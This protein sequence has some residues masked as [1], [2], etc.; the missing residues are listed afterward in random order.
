MVC[1]STNSRPW[2]YRWSIT[3]DVIYA[4][5]IVYRD[6]TIK[7]KKAIPN[8]KTSPVN[9]LCWSD[10]RQL[11]I[12]HMRNVTDGF[13]NNCYWFRNSAPVLN[14]LLPPCCTLNVVVVVQDGNSSRFCKHRVSSIDR[15][16]SELWPIKEK[17]RETSS[18]IFC[19]KLQLQYA[20]SH[21]HKPMTI[22]ITWLW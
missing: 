3:S 18:W 4:Q 20:P 6:M 2:Q 10:S 1:P 7:K 5:F 21:E 12:K 13:V 14:V 11:F 19:H 9:I 8:M 15:S 16:S 17:S 22:I